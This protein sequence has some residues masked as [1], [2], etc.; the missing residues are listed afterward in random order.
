M[1]M[2]MYFYMTSQVKVLFEKWDTNNTGLYILTL[3][4]VFVLCIIIEGLQYL[5]HNVQAYAYSRLTDMIDKK[6]KRVY[7]LSCKMRFLV[8]LLYFICIF[9]S[10][11]LM[12][13][14]M[15]FNGG[16]FIACVLGLTTGY[17][18]FGFI[19]RKSYTRIYN[20]EGDKC[21]TEVDG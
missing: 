12:L 8:A 3:I 17:S 9:L 18:L 20:P 13:I 4:F 2:Q 21:C 11:L 6:D 10:Y 1:P 15:T 7:T 19:K 16:I 14:V 5:R